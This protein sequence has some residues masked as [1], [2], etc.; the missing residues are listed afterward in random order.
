MPTY[1]LSPFG[2][3][4][5]DYLNRH[6]KVTYSN[7]VRKGQVKPILRPL[8]KTST[9]VAMPFISADDYEQYSANPVPGDFS[10]VTR[11]DFMLLQHSGLTDKFAALKILTRYSVGP[12]VMRFQP[13]LVGYYAGFILSESYP[14]DQKQMDT[15]VYYAVQKYSPFTLEPTTSVIAQ[16]ELGLLRRKLILKTP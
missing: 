12:L 1:S 14:V 2:D 4:A 5:K 11:D 8:F 9:L 15:Y 3:Q 16:I 7:I 13:T 6:S 10:P